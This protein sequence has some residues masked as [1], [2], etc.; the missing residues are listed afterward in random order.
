[1]NKNHEKCC[2]EAAGIF[3]A[4]KPLILRRFAPAPR[5]L[6]V[7]FAENLFFMPDLRCLFRIAEPKLGH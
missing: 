3:I 1:M 4:E 7:D 2:K 5:C 6:I